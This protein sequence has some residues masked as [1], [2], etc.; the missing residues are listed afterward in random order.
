MPEEAPMPQA[1]VIRALRARA[2]D[3][4]I[5]RPLATSTGALTHVPLV[6]VD[7]DTDQGITGVTYVF[8]PGSYAVKPLAAMIEA[9]GE[10]VRGEPVAPFAV[11]QKLRKRMTL[12][13]VQGL[14]MLALSGIDTACW[15]AHAKSA[16]LP[17]AR[18]LGGVP[19]PVPA[20][21]SNGLGLMGPERTAAQA[22]ELLE[23]GFK[24]VKVRLGYAT[25]AEDIAVVRA[26]RRAVGESITLM[27]DYNQALPPPEAEARARAL[28]GEGLAWIE[29]PV[30]FDDY[31]GCARVAAAVATPIQIGENCWGTH[32]MQK[33]LDAHACDF[34]MPDLAKIGGV[35]GW[36]RA[37]ALAEPIGLPVSTHLF[38]EVSVHLMCVT[39]TAHWLEYMDWANP[40]LAEPLEIRDGSAIVPERPGNGMR[41]NEEAV[42][43]YLA[44]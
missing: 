32:D 14:A 1:P 8:T 37:A 7:L 19:R 34:F 28:D 24:A 43:R 26:V 6:L 31:A 12:L 4:P 29:E 3:V 30:R 15:D 38:P 16:G 25:V 9:L 35:S 22:V 33:A 18:L 27:S 10:I 17:L 40:I 5:R 2:L 23:G 44:R 41:W 11:E 36:L 39:P 20:Y 42:A 21:N 13:G